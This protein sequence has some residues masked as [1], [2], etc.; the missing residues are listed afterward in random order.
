M[1][2]T[3]RDGPGDIGRACR[4][5]HCARRNIGSRSCGRMREA[6]SAMQQGAS[7]RGARSS[8]SAPNRT[9]MGSYNGCGGAARRPEPSRA[10]RPRQEHRMTTSRHSQP[11]RDPVQK[12]IQRAEVEALLM[13]PAADLARRREPEVAAAALE[14]ERLLELLETCDS[15]AGQSARRGDGCLLRLD[16]VLAADAAPGE[17]RSRDRRRHADRTARIPL[18]ARSV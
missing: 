18:V 12:L 6:R 2:R 14:Y 15:G 1:T 9:V 4:R 11:S 3:S 16:A 10:R 17:L 8:S 7:S 5:G 13:Q